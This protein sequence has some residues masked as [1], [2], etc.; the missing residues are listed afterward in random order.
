MTTGTSLDTRRR[1]APSVWWSA[2]L[3][4][5]FVFFSGRWFASFLA[6]PGSFGYDARLYATAA[7]AMLEGRN[8]YTA[9]LFGGI[10]AGPP[11]S[12]VPLVPFAYLPQEVV[13]AT[14][15]TGNLIIAILVLRRLQLPAWWLAFPPLFFS[16]VMGS[17]EVLMVGLLVLGGPARGLAVV[18][19]PYAA[20]PLLA[21]RLWR[22]LAIG[23]GAMIVSLVVLPWGTFLAELPRV[24]A[25]FSS[26]AFGT[27]ATADPRLF[28]LAAIAL[29]SLGLRRALW[30]ATPVLSPVA[31]PHY[32]AITLPMLTPLLALFWAIQ[33]PGAIVAG[34]IVLAVWERLAPGGRH[35]PSAAPLRSAGFGRNADTGN[36]G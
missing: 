19:K 2:I 21:E 16:I 25:A 11:T 5:V 30:L 23:V 10:F 31:Q 28:V 24:Q 20:L 9:D 27:N 14:W 17:V 6:G 1:A 32:A 34:I 3:P 26:Q 4:I 15:I 7:R 35:S 18:V 33:V 12:L 13:A 29:A 8:P 36:V 22:D